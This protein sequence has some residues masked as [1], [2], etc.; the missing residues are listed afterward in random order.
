MRREL[1]ESLIAFL[2][3][4]VRIF[5]QSRRLYLPP[6]ERSRRIRERHAWIA[7]LRALPDDDTGEPCNDATS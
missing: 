4:D 7:A 5:E 6:A 3:D 2:E 1:R